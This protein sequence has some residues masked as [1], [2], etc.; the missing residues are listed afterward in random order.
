MDSGA[1]SVPHFS[2]SWNMMTAHLTLYVQV[3]TTLNLA[4]NKIGDSG[5]Q[6]L[7]DALRNNQVSL[8]LF[9]SF[10]SLSYPICTGT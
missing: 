4:G 1:E 3:L 10:S 2:T 8:T 7:A 5:A 6:H 9:S